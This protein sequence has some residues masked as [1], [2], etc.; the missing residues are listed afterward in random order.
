ML[1]RS[2]LAIAAQHPSANR[3]RF[4]KER[5]MLNCVAS[6][7]LT[8][9]T[10]TAQGSSAYFMDKLNFLS[11]SVHRLEQNSSRASRYILVP[12][13]PSAPVY[14]FWVQQQPEHHL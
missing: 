12:C 5:F 4:I 9:D 11:L 14:G 1:I 13:A 6:L 8:N 3:Q 2:T 10:A 7:F